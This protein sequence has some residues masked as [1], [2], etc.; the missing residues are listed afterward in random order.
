VLTVQVLVSAPPV[1]SYFLS[2]D[3]LTKKGPFGGAMREVL[4][5]SEGAAMLLNSS[6]L[7][8]YVQHRFAQLDNDQTQ[9]PGRSET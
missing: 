9:L 6:G 8:C 3:Q 4:E 2:P 1:Q 5:A 7:C